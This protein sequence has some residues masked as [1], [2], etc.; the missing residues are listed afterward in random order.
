VSS[1]LN[2]LRADMSSLSTLCTTSTAL[3]QRFGLT[4]CVD[5][6]KQYALPRD[7]SPCLEETRVSA[8][9]PRKKQH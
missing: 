4:L 3:L 6:T 9:Q 2:H 8:T 1:L 7:E 5:A